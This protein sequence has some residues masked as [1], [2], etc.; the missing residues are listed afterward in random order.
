MNFTVVIYEKLILP[1]TFWLNAILEHALKIV[2][3]Y[4][5]AETLKIS[6]SINNTETGQKPKE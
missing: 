6:D 5:L 3:S 4:L 2:L 1:L